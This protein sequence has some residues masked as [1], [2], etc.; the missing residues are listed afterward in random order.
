MRIAFLGTPEFAIPSLEKLYESGHELLVITQP[1]KKQGRKQ[2]LTPPPVKLFAVSNNI[3]VRQFLN[4]KT[5][6]GVEALKEFAPDLMV[7][8]AFGQILSAEILQIP[9]Y[10]CINVH[11]SLLPKYRGAAPIQQAIMNGDKVT[12]ITTMMTDVGLDTGDILLSHEIDIH[13]DETA[14]E[15]TERLSHVGAQTLIHTINML[16]NETLKRIPQDN[17]LA[18]KCRPITRD[19]AKIDCSKSALS[20]HNLVRSMNPWPGAYVYLDDISIKIWKTEPLTDGTSAENIQPGAIASVS[21]RKEL[22][23]QTGEGVLRILE[24]QP[25]NGK[26]MEGS[27]FMNGKLGQILLSDGRFS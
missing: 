19:M 5:P 22:L 13:P 21:S 3:P 18:T 10:G 20:I 25:Q 1:D 23:I 15:L 14:G 2:L 6:E 17:S 7:T 8:A 9:K 27:A 24:L 4:I 12:G 16:Q 26:R 11:A